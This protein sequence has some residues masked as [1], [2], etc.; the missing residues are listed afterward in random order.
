MEKLLLLFSLSISG[1]AFAIPSVNDSSV[2]KYTKAGVSSEIVNTVVSIESN[3]GDQLV[4][5]SI[6]NGTQPEQ[7]HTGT[8][9]ELSAVENALSDCKAPF[10]Y[11]VDGSKE[12]VVTKIGTFKNA[13]HYILTQNGV[14]SDVFMTKDVPFY[15][16]KM[17]SSQLE[18]LEI[19][20]FTKH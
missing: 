12:D 5:L 11:Y 9:S 14:T 8:M 4:T 1:T 16:I 18:S 19:V 20:Q 7:L 2:L 13:C 10:S 3:Q 15:F 6:K 17:T